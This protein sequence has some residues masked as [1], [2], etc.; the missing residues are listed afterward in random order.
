MAHCEILPK[1]MPINI[2]SCANLLLRNGA[3]AHSR[4]DV[5]NHGGVINNIII[6]VAE[7]AADDAHVFCQG[8]TPRPAVLKT[9][10]PFSASACPWIR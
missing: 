3:I 2:K 10:L 8:E 4:H 6:I 1:I 5:A 9:S 7:K